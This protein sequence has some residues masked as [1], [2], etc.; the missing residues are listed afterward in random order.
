VGVI[1]PYNGQVRLLA[2]RF[3]LEGWLERS[4]SSLGYDDMP[5]NKTRVSR[6]S[7]KGMGGEGGSWKVGGKKDE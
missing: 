4:P 2:D 3:R 5:Y 6:N 7:D 1:T